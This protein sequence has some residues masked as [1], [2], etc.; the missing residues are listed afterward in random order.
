MK[1]YLLTYQPDTDLR[2]D[3]YL[4]FVVAAHDTKEAREL[5]VQEKCLYAPEQNIKD[6]S[7]LSIGTTNFLRA[8]IVLKSFKAG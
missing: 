7:C 6:F 8:R 5:I 3:V 2:W 4:G 1:L